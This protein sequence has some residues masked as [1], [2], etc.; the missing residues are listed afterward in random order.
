MNLS[1][2]IFGA[3]LFCAPLLS[4][5]DFTGSYD[6]LL[7]QTEAV[8][9]T[10]IRTATGQYNGSLRDKAQNYVV[11]AT[12]EGNQ[13][14]GTASESDLG[15]TFDLTG[16]L[17]G[18]QLTLDLTLL[19]MTTSVIMQKTITSPASTIKPD[20][21]APVKQGKQD[22]AVVGKW[23]RQTN[24]QSG[25]GMDGTMSSEETIRFNGDG[26]LSDEGSRTVVGGAGWSGTAAGSPGGVIQG[27]SWYTEKQQLF[28]ITHASGTTQTIP[29]GR[30][31]IEDGKMLLTAADGTKVLYYKN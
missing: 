13:L 5:Q 29:L 8:T 6:G 18:S 23:T 16:T 7:N 19:G 24:Y 12:S 22:P 25:Y 28:L 9:L 11:Q 17:S 15:I 30:Y 31:F 1:A 20:L 3:A 2:S 26:T 27:W 14:T 4:A 21:S 10:L